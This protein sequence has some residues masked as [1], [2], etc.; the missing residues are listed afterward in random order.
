MT[1]LGPKPKRAD[2]YITK[3]LKWTKTLRIKDVD[4][5]YLDLTGHTFVGKVRKKYT[6]VTS[7]DF[8]FTL[9]SS[10]TIEWVL[11]AAAST[12]MAVGCSE[13]D[14]SSKYVYDVVWTRPGNDPVCIIKGFV[15]L[16]PKAS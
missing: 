9:V 2:I 6:D 15:T 13:N 3:G 11:P 5:S 1:I 4:G 10:T 8:V 7:Y 12:V 14:P 16:S